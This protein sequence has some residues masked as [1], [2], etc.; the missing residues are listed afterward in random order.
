[1]CEEFEID[2][3]FEL[4]NGESLTQLEMLYTIFEDHYD[5][6]SVDAVYLMNCCQFDPT[7]E[8]L[9]LP[10]WTVCESQVPVV[11]TVTKKPTVR[12]CRCGQTTSA[13]DKSMCVSCFKERR[14]VTEVK[15]TTEFSLVDFIV[16]D[17]HKHKHNNN[18]KHK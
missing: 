16:P 11:T 13:P 1:M 4:E 2:D 17:K 12:Q 18:R 3:G 8:M 7:Y 14:E 15:P 5:Q 10:F 6:V 9:M